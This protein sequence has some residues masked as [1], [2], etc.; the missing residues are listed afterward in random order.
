M[1][2]GACLV[3]IT[4]TGCGKHQPPSVTPAPPPI[5]E[6]APRDLVELVHDLHAKVKAAHV[7][8]DGRDGHDG[9]PGLPGVGTP[10]PTGPMG[11]AGPAG[12][13]GAQGLPG[14]AGPRGEAGPAGQDAAPVG[15]DAL[16][17]RLAKVERE[18]IDHVSVTVGILFA[19]FV[20]GLYHAFLWATAKR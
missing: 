3:A 17:T 1:P 8:K 16:E 12:P 7:A 19:G 14:P 13:R 15:L 2:I 9:Q 4:L 20:Y 5:V 6:T 18:A 11:P 10:G